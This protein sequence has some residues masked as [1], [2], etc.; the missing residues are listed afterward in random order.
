M[1]KQV[2]L[3]PDP[4]RVHPGKY[5]YGEAVPANIFIDGQKLEAPKAGVKIGRPMFP[6]VM[7]R[8]VAVAVG[9]FIDWDAE[10]ED[11]HE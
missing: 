1:S 7:G 3:R 2:T 10:E 9:D 4:D 11:N 5:R 6:D 8:T